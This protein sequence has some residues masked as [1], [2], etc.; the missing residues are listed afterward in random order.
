MQILYP[1]QP[2]VQVTAAATAAGSSK[3]SSGLHGTSCAIR[4]DSH[5]SLPTTLPYVAQHTQDFN[6][7][8]LRQPPSRGGDVLPADHVSSP[9]AELGVAEIWE[10]IGRECTCQGLC[11]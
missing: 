4:I 3:A 5:G 6:A 8:P 10:G 9:F 7:V 11:P 1:R 2:P